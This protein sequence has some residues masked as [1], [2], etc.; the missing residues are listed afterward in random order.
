MG[1][2]ILDL[3][4]NAWGS[5]YDSQKP[6]YEVTPEISAVVGGGPR[7][8]ATKLLPSIG[9]TS[10]QIANLFTGTSNQSAP[11]SI[12]GSNSGST[13]SSD[14]SRSDSSSTNAGAIAG[15]TVGGVVFVAIVATALYGWRRRRLGRQRQPTLELAARDAAK[16]ESSHFSTAVPPSIADPPYK[17]QSPLTPTSELGGTGVV[18]ELL[19]EQFLAELPEHSAKPWPERGHSYHEAGDYHRPEPYGGMRTP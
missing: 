13:P 19:G 17:P 4:T 9:W 3:S 16:P 8:G 14:K 1:V 7:G 15:G 10:F 18:N 6:P 11:Y 12:P 5:V 2:A